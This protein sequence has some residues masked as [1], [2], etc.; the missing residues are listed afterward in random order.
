MVDMDSGGSGDP[1]ARDGHG[2]TPSGLGAALA[3]LARDAPEAWSRVIAVAGDDILALARRLTGD[4][5]L[6][7]DAAQ[8]VLLRL[9]GSVADFRADYGGDADGD[10]G[11]AAARR[12]VMGV[13][14]NVALKLLR[15]QRR[16]RDRDRRHGADAGSPAH[17]AAPDERLARAEQDA[18][19]RAE[20]A[21]LPEASGR[22]I[23]L[24]HLA[25]L[26]F[27]EVAAQLRMPVGTAKTRVR[28]GLVELRGR[29]ERRGVALEAGALAVL[30]GGLPAPAAPSLAL[31]APTGTGAVASAVPLALAVK[32]A[33]GTALLALAAAPFAWQA[34]APKAAAAPATPRAALARVA[35]GPGWATVGQALSRGAAR[36]GVGFAG[37]PTQ[38]DIK[39]TW[40]DGSIRFAVLSARVPEAATHEVVPSGDARGAAPPTGTAMPRVEARF[41]FDG[42]MYRAQLPSAPT[43]DRWLDGPLV[44]EWRW[45]TQPVDDAGAPQRDLDVLMDVR[46][47][48]DGATRIDLAVG[49]GRDQAGAGSRAYEVEVLIDGT[50]VLTRRRVE[51]P[52]L[53]RWRRTF[54]L[55]LT[56][57]DAAPD[58]EALARSGAIPRFDPSVRPSTAP[59]DVGFDL[60][61][62]GG[63]ARGQPDEFDG[64]PEHGPYP[65]WCARYLIAPSPAAR[66]RVMAFGDLSGSWG[67][68]IHEPDGGVVSIDTRPQVWLDERG[69]PFTPDPDRARGDLGAASLGR[70]RGDALR[71][72]AFAYLPYLIGGDRWHADEM[73]ALATFALLAQH[74]AY[75]RRGS[76]GLLAGMEPIGIAWCL[77]DLADAAAYLPDSDPARPYLAAKLQANLAWCDSYARGSESAS[78][79]TAPP[80]SPTSLFAYADDSAGADGTRTLRI[81]PYHIASLAWALGHCREQ[82]FTAGDALRRR[83]L[84]LLVALAARDPRLATAEG[85][86]IGAQDAA[87]TR[88]YLAPSALPLDG[89]GDAHAGPGGVRALAARAALVAAGSERLASADLVAR[90]GALADAAAALNAGWALAAP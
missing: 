49:N 4:A 25:G 8:E 62:D 52:Y 90:V 77:R 83:A 34:L 5:E 45:R 69:Q 71:P 14:A 57:T 13:T 24:H 46:R 81:R 61:G 55:G 3:D 79:G 35:L 75:G 87:G 28:R 86:A 73:R 27:E 89:L 16:A 58:A 84:E 32:L 80:D 22:A 78:G 63:I 54:P 51:H 60:L 48:A 41:V 53:C 56:Q 76:Q 39:T 72:A 9:R 88:R 20:L 26:S 30:L 33:A 85:L 70:L 1:L 66:E 43:A 38:C 19:V 36:D 50:S 74:P 10:G 31:A 64:R 59:G 37:L 21:R 42:R 12:W 7:R 44:S 29:L 68:H 82:G 47:Y 17:T 6:A 18:L 40:D 65:D 67:F 2:V 15:T 11:D 23:A